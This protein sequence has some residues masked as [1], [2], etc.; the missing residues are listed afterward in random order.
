[1]PAPVEGKEKPMSTRVAKSKHPKPVEAASEPK[2]SVP[3]FPSVLTKGP[4]TPE[5][6][7]QC[8]YQ[9]WEAAGRPPGD[10]VRF[11]LE[12]ERELCQES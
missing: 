10:G 6:I 12:A 9:K 3:A 8:A 4:V 11:W 1:V 5:A 7:R 2:E